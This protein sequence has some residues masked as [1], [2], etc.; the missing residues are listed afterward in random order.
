M[1]TEQPKT[2]PANPAAEGPDA[3]TPPGG[4]QRVDTPDTARIPQP[5]EHDIRPS[6]RVD[7]DLAE[8]QLNEENA[9]TSMDQPSEN[10]E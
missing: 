6:E 10:V 4:P 7:P 5:Q 8:E 2:G 1:E 3:P 9:A